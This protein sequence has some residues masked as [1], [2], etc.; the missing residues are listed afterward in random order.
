MS[1]LTDRIFQTAFE[2]LLNRDSEL[3]NHVI[4]EDQE[5]DILE[6]Q[7]DQGSRG[8]LQ[9]DIAIFNGAMEALKTQ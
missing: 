4:A 9:S 5:I 6:K 3:C 7:V 1:S 2:A 8:L